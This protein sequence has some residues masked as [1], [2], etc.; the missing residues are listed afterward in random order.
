MSLVDG[1]KLANILHPN[2]GEGKEIT[3]TLRMK[4]ISKFE[5]FGNGRKS[6]KLTFSEIDKSLNQHLFCL[7]KVQ[8]SKS[9]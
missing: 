5:T 3:L 6:L 8:K 9:S 7:E 4:G 2:F 1:E